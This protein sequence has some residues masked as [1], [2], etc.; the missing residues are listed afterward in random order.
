MCATRS[1]Q[2]SPAS[3]ILGVEAKI[4][5]SQVKREMLFLFCAVHLRVALFLFIFIFF[6][7]R[8]SPLIFEFVAFK[9]AKLFDN[10]ITAATYYGKLEENSSPKIAAFFPYIEHFWLP[11]AQG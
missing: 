1:G 6:I 9:D 3:R 10:I 7:F 11:L 8:I 2:I 4:M 5:W